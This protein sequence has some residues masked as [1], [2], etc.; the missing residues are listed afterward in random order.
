MNLG[1]PPNI[2]EKEYN[3]GPNFNDE[4][5]QI[6][7]NKN[8]IMNRQD[9]F[10]WQS[11]VDQHVSLRDKIDGSPFTKAIEDS[12]KECTYKYDL[13][14]IY[15]QVNSYMKKYGAASLSTLYNVAT[16]HFY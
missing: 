16:K 3:D 11:T 2:A 12:F 5:S 9:F 15:I 10:I 4:I 1:L 14:E 7:Q 13:Y 6:R 8:A